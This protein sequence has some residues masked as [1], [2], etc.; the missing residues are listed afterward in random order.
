MQIKKPMLFQYSKI[1][2]PKRSVQ[3]MQQISTE[4][5]QA[6][7]P[8]RNNR[9][10]P[11]KVIKRQN[12]K[13][14]RMIKQGRGFGELDHPESF[15]VNLTNVSHMFTNIWWQGKKV[16][17]KFVILPT[18]K[19]Q[20][21]KTLLNNGCKIGFSSR[22]AGSLIQS[23]G[24]SPDVVDDDYDLVTY[25]AVS[26]PSSFNAWVF[27]QGTKRTVKRQATKSELPLL[28]GSENQKYIEDL[29]KI[30]KG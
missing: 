10:Y 12:D 17:G 2:L 28:N 20:I 15:E 19:G 22:G 13:F 6:D 26:W 14:L 30:L 16:F 29:Y 7:V 1:T 18:P 25:D 9:I 3:F 11:T 4:L 21:F 23:Y 27:Y 5:S 8:N 24:D